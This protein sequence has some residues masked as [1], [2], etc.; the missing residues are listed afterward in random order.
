MDA[1]N[2]RST[3]APLS[4]SGATARWERIGGAFFRARSVTPIGILAAALLWPTPGGL[5][6]ARLAGAAALLVAGEALRLWAVGVA[7]KLTRTRGSNVKGLVTSGPFGF[8]RNPLYLGNFAIAG[9]VAVL[10]KV[11]WLLWAMPLLFALQYAAIVAWEER[12][13]AQA[14]GEA[15]DDYRRGVRRWVPSPRRYRGAAGPA[16]AAG[17]AWRS[18]RDTLVGLAAVVAL[19]VVK[20]LAAHGSIAAFWLGA[21]RALGMAR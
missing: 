3:P 4:P 13:L 17:I 5:T 12:V 16:W 11:G 9:G 21:A 8:V 20:H 7:G 19:L 15:Y 14:F 2:A 6:A 10:S 1:L 18:E